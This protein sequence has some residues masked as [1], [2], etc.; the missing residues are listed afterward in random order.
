ME[1]EYGSERFTAAGTQSPKELET[2][3]S[4]RS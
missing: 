4:K 2:L 3:L 1:V